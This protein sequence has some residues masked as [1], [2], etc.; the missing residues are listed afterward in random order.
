MKKED[1]KSDRNDVIKRVL[2]FAKSCNYDKEHSHQATR[3]ALRLFD[4]FRSLH[5][6]GQ[7]EKSYLQSASL[8]HDIALAQGV[9]R[10][11][12]NALEMIL[13]SRIL[14]FDDNERMIV[15][16]VARYH[17]RALPKSSHKY[18]PE[19]K[20]EPKETVKR[21][22]SLLRV[23]DGLDRTHMSA[24]KNLSCEILPD[25]VIIHIE[26]NDLSPENKEA[27]E[28]KADLFEKVFQK[29]LVID[30]SL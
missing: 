6:L 21:L 26:A 23:A 10:H 29:K 3:L 1:E 14:P 12:K 2:E 7:K 27:T 11:H 30:W 17:R 4:E 5:T 9:R 20:P 28:K 13:K 18:F 25:K 8:L 15:A 24:V 19:L 16:L 22:A